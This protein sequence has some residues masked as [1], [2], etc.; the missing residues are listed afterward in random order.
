[1]LYTVLL[2][3]LGMLVL[4]LFANPV[5]GIF[6]ISGEIQ[7]LCVKAIRIV[8]V[9]YAFA[10]ANIAFQGIFQALGSGVK[11]LIVSLVRLIVVN[12]PLAWL[13]TTFQNAESLV[14]LAFPAAEAVA[15]VVALVLMRSVSKNK[16]EHIE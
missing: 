14:W 10:G 16:I 5:C 13:L 1:M 4:Q 11:S 6:A 8:T 7:A 3:L 2:M 12:L 15:L 9:G